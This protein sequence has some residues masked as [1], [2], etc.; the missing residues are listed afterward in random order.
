MFIDDFKA[1]LRRIAPI[2]VSASP[3]GVLFGAVAVQHGM[4]T[5]EAVLMSG[6]IYAGASQLVG[7]N[8]FDQHLPA[9]VVILS[10][11]A[12]NFRHILYSAAIARHISLLSPWQKALNFFL[13]TD[14]HY[15]EIERQAQSGE[16][17]TFGWVMGLGIG[18]YIPWMAL[19]YA[20]CV[21]GAFIGDPKS[22][23]LDVLLPVYFL[24]LVMGFRKRA[25]WLPVVIAS[26]LASMAA[27]KLVGSPWHVSIGALA[28]IIVAALMPLPRDRHS[29][30]GEI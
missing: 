27:V 12:V 13:L 19:T 9:W 6:V 10:I 8:L 20:G 28:G 21:L 30:I 2:I 29:E 11:L 7:V 16:P 24:G 17:I 5:A 18:L 15:A 4:S 22:I 25:N 14:P 23:G 3:F 1:G 26:S